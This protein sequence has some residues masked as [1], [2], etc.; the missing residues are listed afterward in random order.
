M[1]RIGKN[2]K[3]RLQLT[4]NLNYT[5][6][7]DWLSD[8][9]MR[10]KRI[11]LLSSTLTFQTMDLRSTDGTLTNN[12]SVEITSSGTTFARVTALSGTL[13]LIYFNDTEIT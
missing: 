12:Y 1:N 6:I 2:A 13:K 4:D 9:N 7:I 10:I 8:D 11:K 3:G 5:F